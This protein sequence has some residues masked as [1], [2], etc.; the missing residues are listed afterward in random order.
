MVK[1]Q[2]VENIEETDSD[3]SEGS[4]IEVIKKPNRK[5]SKIEKPKPK[6][7]QT[8]RQKEA[9]AKARSVLLAKLA[10]N[11]LEKLEEQ[12]VK[13]ELK[14]KVLAKKEKKHISRTKKLQELSESDDSSSEEEVIVKKR[15]KKKVVYVDDDEKHKP[16][17]NI[18]NNGKDEKKPDDIPVRK[19]RGIF[20]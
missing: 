6:R 9:F 17:I 18:Y 15:S 13:D 4:T 2:I 3:S 19:P 14:T 16:I 10:A 20:L 12:R 5:T 11:K 7:E 8:E 1:K